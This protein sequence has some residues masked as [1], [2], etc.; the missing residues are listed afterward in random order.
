MTER[1]ITFGWHLD[2][3]RSTEPRNTLGE[4]I[5]GPMGFLTL[6][7]TQLGLMARH[8]AQTERI[9]QYR[10]CLQDLDADRRFYHQS[11]LVDSTGYGGLSA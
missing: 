1:R 10:I 3:Q 11:F 4:S 6:L 7:E 9:V 8:P 2:G 5:V